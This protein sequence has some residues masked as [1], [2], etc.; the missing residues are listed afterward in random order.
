[1]KFEIY[2]LKDGDENRFIKFE[3]YENARE[4]KPELS[5]RDY[6][7]VYSG[8]IDDVGND[9]V[10]LESLY[11]K[12]NIDIPKGFVGNHSLS[13]SDIIK[14]GEKMYYVDVFGY[15]EVNI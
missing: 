1:M 11:V 14:L 5:I 4:R 9:M 13:V 6:N 3:S 8:E 15:K 12:F 7:H 2:Q 10:M